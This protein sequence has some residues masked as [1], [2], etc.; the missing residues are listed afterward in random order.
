MNIFPPISR[1]PTQSKMI[2]FLIYRP[3][4]WL[5]VWLYKIMQNNCMIIEGGMIGED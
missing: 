4:L 5:I 2:D 1:Y 3:A